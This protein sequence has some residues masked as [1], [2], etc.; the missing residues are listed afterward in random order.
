M[1][2]LLPT[3]NIQALASYADRHEL[4]DLFEGIIGRMVIDK[5]DDAI[6]FM[7][8][9][10]QKSPTHGIVILGPPTSGQGRIAEQLALTLDLVQISAG[11]LLA[12]AIERQTSL[13]TQA[14]PY[15]ERG[16][17]V[18]DAVMLG[19]VM[20]RLQDP[21]VALRGFVLEGFPRTKDQAK[22]LISRGVLPTRIIVFEIPEE[23]IVERQTGTRIDPLTNRLYHLRTN[24]P[25]DN[26]T[27]LARLIQRQT[28]KPDAIRKRLAQYR[29][30][31]RGVTEAFDRSIV[32]TVE[33]GEGISEKGDE[34]LGACVREV[35]SGKVTRA[36]RMV[37]CVV[38]GLPGCGKTVVAEMMGREFGVVVV[39]PRTV[40]LELLSLST[41]KSSQYAQYINDP[42]SVPDDLILPLILDRLQKR[43]CIDRGWVLDGFPR[44]KVQA[45]AL[46]DAGIVPNRI[47]FLHATPA[48][49][50]HRLLHS[51]ASPSTNPQS[52]IDAAASLHSDILSI[53]APGRAKGGK[54]RTPAGVKP[55]ETVGVVQDIDADDG[56]EGG[57]GIERVFER[58]RGAMVRSNKGAL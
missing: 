49:C 56:G 22:G 31:L 39:S 32:R 20:S 14:R 43:H 38:A 45:D 18:P 37:R 21:E 30:H 9:Q 1:N 34:A 16:E 46:K 23:V 58:V 55:G 17:Y 57:E 2:D 24:P 36:P 52:R 54:G 42:D 47:L 5:P 44:T 7:I 4:F 27:L 6:Q 33:L 25:P 3:D 28:D 40:L 8:E 51:P 19:L 41:P 15:L 10:L 53:Y 26:P 12:T 35:E 48:T 13:G 50:L 11:R 29:R